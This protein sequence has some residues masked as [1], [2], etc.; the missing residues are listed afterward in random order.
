[1]STATA[2]ASTCGQLVLGSFS[3]SIL[4]DPY[5]RALR[6]QRRSGAVLFA[7]NVESPYQLAALARDVHAACPAP[8]LA[9]DQEGGRVARLRAPFVRVPAMRAVAAGGDVAMAERIARVVGIELAA[10]GFTMNLAPVLDVHTRAD[11]PVIGDRAFGDDP[12]TCVRFGRAWIRGLQSAGL[13]AT[14]K[15]F[16]G[17]GDTSKDSHFDLPVVEQPLERLDRVELAPFRA[18]ASA[19]VAAM[20]TAH[21]VYP[22]IDPE[23]PATLS[24]A[25]CTHLREHIGFDGMLVSDDLEMQAISARWSTG[26]AAVLAVAAGCDAVLVCGTYDKQEAAVDALIGEAERSAAFRARCQQALARVLEA[27]GRATARPLGDEA[28]GAL[29]DAAESRAGAAPIAIDP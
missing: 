7:S 16:P 13:L 8:L 24:P 27:R 15:H 3:G 14:A 9:V 28:I 20:M 26:D 25:I 29:L 17:H 21:V 5:A 19:G 11:N 1:M 2:L 23:R 22:A 10:V 6:E 12:E 4:P 18:A